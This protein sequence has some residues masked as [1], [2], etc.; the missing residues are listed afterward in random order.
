MDYGVILLFLCFGALI[1]ISTSARN[2]AVKYTATSLLLGSVF[3]LFGVPFLARVFGPPSLGTGSYKHAR[4]WRDKLAQCSSPNDVRQQFDCGSWQE[5]PGG[6]F[7]YIRDPNAAR[8]GATEARLC[9]LPNGDW[10]AIAY[11]SSHNTWGGGTI[12]TRDSTGRI[13]VFFGHVCGRPVARGNSLEELYACFAGPDWKEV[14][15]GE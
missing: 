5:Q 14:S 4:L 1:V 9:D 13:R 11:A 6:S 7:R 12:A 8:D 3:I 2:K 10:L 15:L